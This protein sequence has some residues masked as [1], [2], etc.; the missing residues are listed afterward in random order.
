MTT[1]QIE[2]TKKAWP[3][4]SST[5]RVPH[6]QEDYEELVD[7]LD[8]LVDEVGEDDSNPLASLME[9]IG[10]LIE[11]YEDENVPELGEQSA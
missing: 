11:K 1:K 6:S 2:Q 7:L 9:M 4:L 3:M 5:L 8:S 10:V